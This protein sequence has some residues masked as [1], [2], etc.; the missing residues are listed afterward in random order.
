[1]SAL[2][3]LQLEHLVFTTVKISAQHLQEPQVQGALNTAV[4]FKTQPAAP[5]SDDR[6][7]VVAVR[8]HLNDAPEDTKLKTP[9]VGTVECVGYFTVSQAWPADKVQ[10]LV[11]VN[12]TGLLY[13][14]IREM[15][16]TIT[17]RGPWGTIMLPTQSF[18]D[19]TKANQPAQRPA[20][21][22]AR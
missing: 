2:S 1:M 20:E 13:S 16:C 15:V 4:E 5:E 9:Y 6:R 3:P 14:A 7:W 8:V 17:A 19:A 21:K 11:A 22:G 10:Q 18:V 12:G